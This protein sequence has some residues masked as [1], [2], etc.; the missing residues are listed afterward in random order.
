MRRGGYLPRRTPLR[1]RRP[2]SAERT[3]RERCVEE[4]WRRDRTCQAERLVPDVACS[5]PRDVHEMV[6]RSL[7]RDAATDPA[8]CLLLCRAHHRW[9]DGNI[10]AAHDRGLLRHSW[11]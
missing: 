5:G 10:A 9:I 1:A 7:R 3:A 8:N 6:Q 2:S 4:V 11:E